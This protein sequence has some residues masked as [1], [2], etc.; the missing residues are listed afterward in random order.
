MKM[1]GI[2]PVNLIGEPIESKFLVASS[3]NRYFYLPKDRTRGTSVEIIHVT[4]PR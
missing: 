2:Q 3:G 4:L 1:R